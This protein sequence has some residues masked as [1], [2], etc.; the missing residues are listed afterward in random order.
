MQDLFAR[1]LAANFTVK[2]LNFSAENVQSV[3]EGKRNDETSINTNAQTTS[4]VEDVVSTLAGI[5]PNVVKTLVD[6]DR[7]AAA[8]TTISTQVLLPTF[9]SKLFPQN[10]T[11]NT[12]QLLNGL[13]KIPEASKIWRKDL[14]EAFNDAKFFSPNSLALADQGWLPVLGQWVF[15]DKDRIP[16]IL[17]RISSPATAGIVFGV[18]ATS[19]RSEAD[20]KTQLNLRRLAL[21]LLAASDD[22]FV[23]SLN[24]FQEKL[25]ELLTATVSSSPSSVTRGEVYML[26]RAL[27][28]KTSPMHLAGFWP[29]VNAELYEAL[30]SL[31]P[32]E[33][34]KS[35]NIHCN[36]QACKL[37]DT[38]L[39][40][41]PDEF[42]LREW[43]FITDTI[44]AVYRP[45]GWAPMALIDNLVEELDSG[46]GLG[47][48]VPTP[49]SSNLAQNGKR[50]P[51]LNRETLQ[52][53]PVKET[54]DR[55][56]RPFF[57]Q[58]SINAFES[59][60]SM[61]QPDW[62]ACHDELLHDLFD[63]STIA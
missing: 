1:L 49:V 44:D 26:L 55:V 43:L 21:L 33:Q 20:R 5:I 2:P 63:D 6:S 16:E 7:I 14:A 11:L 37:L 36:L 48:T 22:S 17:S 8:C 12:L 45:Q 3:P 47:H 32:S 62:K 50:R 34:Y 25:S 30:Y 19:A 56:L 9:R 4:E 53:I 28:L 59:T 51:L 61:E 15:A 23:V 58:L 57:R 54:L 40:L 18:G 31:F 42:Q 13:S 35:S 38:L 46:S 41:A 29:M 24:L 52:G 60:Y 27:I 39:V 10:V